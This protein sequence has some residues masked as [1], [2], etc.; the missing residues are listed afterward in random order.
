MR[1]AV[2]AMGG[3]SAPREVVR[4]A[5][6]AA[7]HAG[8]DLVLVGRERAVEAELANYRLRGL[9]ISIVNADEVVGFDEPPAQGCD[10]SEIHP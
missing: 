2:D 6:L 3:D 7:R 4:G 10:T 5:V 1:I 8:E 9:N